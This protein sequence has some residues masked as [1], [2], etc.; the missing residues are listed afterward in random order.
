MSASA[1]PDPDVLSSWLIQHLE[2]VPFI[3]VDSPNGP[4][5][6]TEI[7][8]HRIECL[9]RLT[10]F[11]NYTLL[12]AAPEPPTFPHTTKSFSDFLIHLHFFLQQEIFRCQTEKHDEA[13]SCCDGLIQTLCQMESVPFIIKID[14]NPLFH[15]FLADPPSVIA[16]K[17]KDSAVVADISQNDL[18]LMNDD[19]NRQVL[20]QILY[21]MQLQYDRKSF[22]LPPHPIQARFDQLLFH[23]N[24]IFSREVSGLATAPDFRQESLRLMENIVTRFNLKDAVDISILSL[25]FFRSTFDFAYGR[26]P[27]LFLRG[28]PSL[29]RRFHGR[30][31]LR[32]TGAA[33]KFVLNRNPDAQ[34]CEIVA[35]DHC[36]VEAAR[37]LTSAAFCSSPLDVLYCVHLA[38]TQIRKS[39]AKIDPEMVQSFDTVFGLF[40]IVL[41]GCDLPEPEAIFDLIE[42]FAPMNGLSGPLEYARST[43]SA[44]SLQCKTIVHNIQA[45]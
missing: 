16:L 11:H 37:E 42:K 35:K 18:T 12:P 24:F 32:D 2:I 6:P 40:L 19:Q 25:I 45:M 30:Y 17:L 8:G 31:R 41:L 33:A 13:K 3:Q 15:H 1:A 7:R 23:P 4:D 34:L 26:R 29:I 22:F 9:Q 38:L 36:L 27:D 44:A 5:W 39:V 21:S 20:S 43:V 28:A 14:F 10:Q